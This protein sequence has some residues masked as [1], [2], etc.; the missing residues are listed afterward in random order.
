MQG[1]RGEASWGLRPR[2]RPLQTEG[3]DARLKGGRYEGN[4]KGNICRARCFAQDELKG[5]ALT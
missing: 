4:C 1:R 5:A 3:K 2:Q